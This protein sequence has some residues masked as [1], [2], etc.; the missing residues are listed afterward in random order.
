VF[1]PQPVTAQT[2]NTY[3]K[4][5][6]M[7]PMFVFSPKSYM[8][9][10]TLGTCLMQLNLS[11]DGLGESPNFSFLDS[12]LFQVLGQIDMSNSSICPYSLTHFNRP[13]KGSLWPYRAADGDKFTIFDIPVDFHS[14][15]RTD[16]VVLSD[17]Y[18]V[19]IYAPDAEYCQYQAI[20]RK[21]MDAYVAG[22]NCGAPP[23][24]FD[25]NANA[26][27]D[28]TATPIVC[29]NSPAPRLVV[30]GQGVVPPVRPIIYDPHH[31]LTPAFS[32]KF[33]PVDALQC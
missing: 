10:S 23:L 12:L 24:Q 1:A 29:P 13:V 22:Y 21:M 26:T 15:G 25:Y 6:A 9:Q 11:P 2:I 19:G 5:G 14:D 7:P 28:A 18:I 8:D 17:E 3:F 27:P 33:Q 16:L 4:G 31:K 20:L 32:V 30:G